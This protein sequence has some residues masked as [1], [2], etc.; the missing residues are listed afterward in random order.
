MAELAA[1][2]AGTETVVADTDGFVLKGIGKVVFALSHGANKDANAFRG[3]QGVDVI[4]DSDYVGVE[5][6]G[7]FPAVWWEMICDGVFNDLQQLF[8]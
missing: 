8:L 7:H 2:N 6:Q 3:A 5:T 4:P 1:G